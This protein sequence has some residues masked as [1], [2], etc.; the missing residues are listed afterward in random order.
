M[1]RFVLRRLL[2]MVPTLVAIS[3][4]VFLI[5]N[6]PPGDYVTSLVARRSAQGQTVDPGEI[7]ALRS[8]YGL[9]Q[10]IWI[11]Y[12]DWVTG[13][14]LRGDFGNSFEF[15]SPV[16]SLVGGVMGNTLLIAMLALSVSWIIA[17]PVGVYAA[18]RQYSIGDYLATTIG[19]LG[20]ATP[21]FLIA[22]ILI[23]VMQRNFGYVPSGFFSPEFRDASWNLGKLLDLLRHIWV[24]VV[25]V[26]T[27]GTAGL[28]RILRANLLDELRKPYV[29]AARARGVPERRLL[30][31]Y[32]LRVALNPFI[33]TVG[34]AFPVALTGEIIV[35]RVLNLDTMGR[36][37]LDA[38]GRQDM[39]LAGGIIMVFS[40]LV[41][42][43]TLIS[44]LLLAWLDPRVRLG[45]TGGAV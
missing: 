8:L 27:A 19:F 4:V 28:I 21:N 35:A 34:W 11:Q 36:M 3:L 29:V 41:V 1:L 30:L 45:Q 5:I 26:G 2:L 13:M 39:Y 42:L 44:D 25:V 38:L 24:P 20:L 15:R 14:V 22:L 32:P 31:R 37:L 16:R 23:Y 33:S 12:W 40:L 18:V 17:F 6:L 43:G 7:A 9:D 10:P